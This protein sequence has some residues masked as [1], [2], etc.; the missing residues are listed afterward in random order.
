MSEVWLIALVAWL[1][2]IAAA[3]GAGLAQLEGSAETEGKQE[4]VHGVLAFGGGILL[5]A[6]AFALAPEGI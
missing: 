1:A 6:V 5:A 3:L 4:L 2:G